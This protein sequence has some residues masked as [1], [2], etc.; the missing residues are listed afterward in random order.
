MSMKFLI[1]GGLALGSV[2]ALA[3]AAKLFNSVIPRQDGVRVDMSEMAD[4]AKWEEYRKVITPRKEAFLAREHED[5]ELT[6]RDG[7]RLHATYFPC[8]EPSDKFVLVCHGYTSTGVGEFAAMSQYY[9]RNGYNCL[10]LDLR[11]HGESE[12]DYYGFG[13]LDRFDCMAWIHYLIERFGKDI[14]IVL[15]GTSMGA[16]TILMVSGA[17]NLPENVRCIVADCAFT[18]PYDVFAHILSR[19][20][21]L[22]AFPIMNIT[23]QMCKSRAGYQFRDY[24]TLIAMRNNTRPVLFV[25]GSEDT[26]VPVWM[27]RENYQACRAPKELLIV[28][29]AGHG[30][31]YFENSALYEETLDGFLGKW[32]Q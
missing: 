20:Y 19:D 17:S 25:H 9:L 15:Q 29:G 28:P 13:I 24:S 8:D 5:V 27:S 16:S 4:M 30:A 31:S 10:V 21:H 2:A 14:Q 22:P 18:S 12:G 3:G 23:D 26:F 32:V 11:A 6:A 1:G 7:I